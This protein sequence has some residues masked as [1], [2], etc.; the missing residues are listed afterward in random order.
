VRI[1][2]Q[3]L[4]H[5]VDVVGDDGAA[6]QLGAQVLAGLGVGQLAGAQQVE[7]VLGRVVGQLGEGD[8]ADQ[9]ALVG[10]NLARVADHGLDP[11]HAADGLGHGD[12]ADHRVAVVLD[13]VAQ[14]IAPDGDLLSKLLVQIRH[15]RL[16]ACTGRIP[17]G[18]PATGLG[19][20]VVIR[21]VP[22]R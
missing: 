16:L 9:Q 1:G 10:R 7:D 5:L 2:G 19:V 22:D 12:L 8:G 13:Q 4:E 14:L 6:R 11:A 15:R 21:E 3:A 18:I 17:P 20:R